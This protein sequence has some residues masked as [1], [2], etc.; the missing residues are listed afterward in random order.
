M[1]VNN[2][3]HVFKAKE[4][5]DTLFLVELLESFDYS[6]LASG[7]AQP[8]ITQ[9]AL[10][11]LRLAVPPL[12]EQKRIGSILDSM[13]SKMRIL[14]DKHACYEKIKRGLMQKLLAGELRVKLEDVETVAA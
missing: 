1:W 9:Q 5:N 7:T 13:E 4:G 12:A 14:R 11:Q 6:H 2:H 3:A 10:R 8:K